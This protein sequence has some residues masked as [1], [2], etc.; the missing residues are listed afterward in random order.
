MLARYY[1]GPWL[2]FLTQAV[3]FVW[4]Y[5]TKDSA[6]YVFSMPNVSVIILYLVEHCSKYRIQDNGNKNKIL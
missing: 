2:M 1:T 5:N 4:G 3:L 6:R